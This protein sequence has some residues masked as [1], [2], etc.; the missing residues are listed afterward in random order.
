MTTRDT[1]AKM[2]N[3]NKNY[4]RV[5]EKHTDKVKKK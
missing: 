3:K 2:G 1:I 4:Y 5:I